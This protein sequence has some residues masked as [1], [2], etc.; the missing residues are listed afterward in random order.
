VFTSERTAGN[1]AGKILKQEIIVKMKPE[2]LDSA[3]AARVQSAK[4][5]KSRKNE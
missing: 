4:F 2:C 1:A 5:P 3:F